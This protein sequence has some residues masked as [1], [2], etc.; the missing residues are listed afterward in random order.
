MLKP[1]ENFTSLCYNHTALESRMSEWIWQNIRN[2]YVYIIYD[3]WH[4]IVFCGFPWLTEIS[5]TSACKEHHYV[6]WCSHYVLLGS[7]TV[8]LPPHPHEAFLSPNHRVPTN[9]LHWRPLLQRKVHIGHSKWAK[10]ISIHWFSFAKT[11]FSQVDF[12]EVSLFWEIHKCLLFFLVLHARTEMSKK[13]ESVG[14]TSLIHQYSSY[15]IVNPHSFHRLRLSKMLSLTSL[16]NLKAQK[17]SVLRSTSC[18]KQQTW[19]PSAGAEHPGAQR[20]NKDLKLVAHL[21]F[22]SLHL[23]LSHSKWS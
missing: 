17:C 10:S 2:T 9:K 15:I 23:T 3:T 16:K 20:K 18:V 8:S 12:E 5:I 19:P 1:L 4:M 22:K 13:H 14:K 6:F 11:I 21:H 7:G